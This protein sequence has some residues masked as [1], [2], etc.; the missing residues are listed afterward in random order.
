MEKYFFFLSLTISRMGLHWKIILLGFTLVLLVFEVIKVK[1]KK[2]LFSMAIV[3]TLFISY[4]A[5]VIIGTVVSREIND[6]VRFDFDVFYH[7]QQCFL[8]DFSYQLECLANIIMFIPFG[9][10]FP[11]YLSV[12][13]NKKN[14]IWLFT[15]LSGASFSFLIELIQLI[16]QR[17]LCELSDLTNN[18][19]GTSIGL[20][21]Y[22]FVKW[23]FQK[24][25][26]GIV[27]HRDQQETV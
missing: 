16:T 7:Y 18:I 27:T 24:I 2:Q 5:L 1:I 19:I 14:R 6:S 12:I 9:I 23:I 17:G 26:K 10:L 20:L 8:G 4:I 15:F 22:Y 21:C 11:L 3:K 25:K 13:C